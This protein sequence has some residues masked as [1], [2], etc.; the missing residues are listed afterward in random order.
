MQ[1]INFV[2]NFISSYIVLVYN[3]QKCIYVNYAKINAKYQ[4]C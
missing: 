1:P 2:Q 4:K 3:K